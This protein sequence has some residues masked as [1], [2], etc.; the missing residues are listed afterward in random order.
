ML[1]CDVNP[2]REMRQRFF[3]READMR[4]AKKV[5]DAQR[6]KNP[7]AKAPKERK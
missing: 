5:R 1:P 7:P 4:E 3:K 6:A 2:E